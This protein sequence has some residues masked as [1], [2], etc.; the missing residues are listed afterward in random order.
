MATPRKAPEDLL[1]R[2]RK[3]KSNTPR[4]REFKVR[5]TEEEEARLVARG[6]PVSAALR[7]LIE[8]TAGEK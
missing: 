8:S 7:Q 3:P 5:I 2:G 4:D 1:R 6:G